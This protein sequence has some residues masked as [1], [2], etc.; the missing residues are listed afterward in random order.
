MFYFASLP[1]ALLSSLSS[2]LPCVQ[3]FSLPEEHRLA[4]LEDQ[5]QQLQKQVAN[6]AS[7]DGK[8]RDLLDQQERE[9]ERWEESRKSLERQLEHEREQRSESVG[10]SRESLLNQRGPAE[11]TSRNG[12]EWTG[13]RLSLERRLAEEKELREKLRRSPL[14]GN[15]RRS[16][17]MGEGFVAGSAL[18]R[19]SR[20]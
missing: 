8:L 17:G 16:G 15:R 12:A 2:P 1:C 9:R 10:G 3:V 4:A 11:M 6:K 14:D 13:S 5:L 20:C 18:Y 19:V 7:S